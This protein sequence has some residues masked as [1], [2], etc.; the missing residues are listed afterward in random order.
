MN[1][2]AWRNLCRRTSSDR[3]SVQGIGF[4]LPILLAGLLLGGTSTVIAQAR[5]P[6]ALQL[7][8]NSTQANA[9]TGVLV[10]SGNVQIDYPARSIKATAAQATYFSREG[11]MVLS[12]NVFVL[13]EGNSLRGEVITYLLNEGRFEATPQAGQQVEA[14]YIMPPETTP[15]PAAQA[16]T[17]PA[18]VAPVT[19]TKQPFPIASP[20][21]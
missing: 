7:R 5:N 21:P 6:Q 3:R 1:L 14:I 17:A 19:S 10:A 18:P 20:S 16:P 2:P 8:A 9:K 13:Q 15:V 11:R 12:G 4:T